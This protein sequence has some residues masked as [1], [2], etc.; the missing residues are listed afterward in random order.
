[1]LLQP[2]APLFASNPTQLR[3]PL[4]LLLLLSVFDLTVNSQLPDIE[5]FFVRP[6]ISATLFSGIFYFIF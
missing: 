6:L 2:V 4:L 5:L 3:Q 1:V